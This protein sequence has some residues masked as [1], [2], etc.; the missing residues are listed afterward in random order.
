M[1][2]VQDFS[3]QRHWVAITSSVIQVLKEMFG[4]LVSQGPPLA[5]PLQP[6]WPLCKSG[7]DAAFSSCGEPSG[8][9][10]CTGAIAFLTCSHDLVPCAG[11]I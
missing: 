10:R 6:M 3:H 7:E 8:M 1:V 5:G 11:Y 9:T 4:L 2:R